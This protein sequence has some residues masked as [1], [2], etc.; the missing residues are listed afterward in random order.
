MDPN[1]TILVCKHEGREVGR[2]AATAPNASAY[3]Q[4]LAEHYKSMTV[5]YVRDENAWLFAAMRGR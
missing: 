2:I 3:V 1:K 5:D 4:T